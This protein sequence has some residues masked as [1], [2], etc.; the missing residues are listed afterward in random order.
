[1]PDPTTVDRTV[2]KVLAAVVGTTS[3]CATFVVLLLIVVAL[4]P[5]GVANG[6]R[7]PGI[8]VD[9]LLGLLAITVGVAVGRA[10]FRRFAR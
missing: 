5:P 8:A 3:C 4:T 1:M 6:S 10:V 7:A 9:V 2:G